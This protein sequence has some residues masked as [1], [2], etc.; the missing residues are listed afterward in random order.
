M[1][2]PGLDVASPG[3]TRTAVHHTCPLPMP[4][5]TETWN[6]T[7]NILRFHP[8]QVGT[9]HMTHWLL[10]RACVCCCREQ[11]IQLLCKITST[12][13][14]DSPARHQTGFTSVSEYISITI[15]ISAD[16]LFLLSTPSLNDDSTAVFSSRKQSRAGGCSCQVG[17]SLPEA[18]RLQMCF[19]VDTSPFPMIEVSLF[20]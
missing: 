14:R 10:H 4:F 1:L 17:L 2:T 20:S 16:Y 6:P 15:P 19:R 9:Q 12:H 13:P 8:F 11:M 5:S 7:V 3:E 18:F